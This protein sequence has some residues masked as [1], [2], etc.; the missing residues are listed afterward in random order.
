MLNVRSGNWTA[1]RCAV[2]VFLYVKTVKAARVEMGDVKLSVNE[3]IL[4][5]SE[6]EM[7]V[8]V[9]VEEMIAGMIEETIDETIDTERMIDGTRIR[10][11]CLM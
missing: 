6:I 2:D 10:R 8:G 3:E 7:I 4:D 5:V 1:P 11:I 9:E